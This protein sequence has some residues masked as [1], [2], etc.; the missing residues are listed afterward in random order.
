VSILTGLYPPTSGH[1]Y[2]NGL[3]ISQ[4]MDEIRRHMGLC[5]QQDLLFDELTGKEHLLIFGRLRGIPARQL[6]R[7]VA[8]TLRVRKYFQSSFVL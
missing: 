7:D 8:E 3:D 4:K 5:P 6:E 1:A 2:V